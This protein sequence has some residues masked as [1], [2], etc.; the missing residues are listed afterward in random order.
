MNNTYSNIANWLKNF[1]CYID[2]LQFPKEFDVNEDIIWDE[3]KSEEKHKEE[4]KR[5]PINNIEEPYTKEFEDPILDEA[6]HLSSE[7]ELLKL[8]RDTLWEINEFETEIDTSFNKLNSKLDKQEYQ[9][10]TQYK[11]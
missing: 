11:K 8:I 1:F 4:F 3:N 5:P 7:D 9:Y 6:F 10:D 2:L